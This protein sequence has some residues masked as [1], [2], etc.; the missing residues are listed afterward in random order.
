MRFSRSSE[1][2]GTTSTA[3]AMLNRVVDA[4]WNTGGKVPRLGAPLEPGWLRL[5]SGLAQIVFY[6][7]ARVAIEGPTERQLISSGH[8]S[9]RHARW[10]IGMQKASR[11]DDPVMIR[12]FSGAMEEFCLFGRALEP[13]E[14]HTWRRSLHQFAPLLFWE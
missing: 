9:C 13:R 7:G 10:T 4:Q 1:R 5:E 3:I 12:N 14:W 8:A 2:N 11:T 6:S